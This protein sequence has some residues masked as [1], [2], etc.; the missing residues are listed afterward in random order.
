MGGKVI[1]RVIIDT[2]EQLP[3]IPVRHVQGKLVEIP[4]VFGTLHTGDYSIEGMERLWALQR[5]SIG[6]LWGTMYG[7]SDL[8]DGTKRYNQDR[9]REEFDRMQEYKR[10]GG[11]VRWIVE[12]TW[13]DLRR[14]AEKRYALW[15]Q[16]G[17]K[18]RQPASY[19][20]AKHAVLAI[21]ADYDV[22]IQF[23]ENRTEAAETIGY[24]FDRVIGQATNKTEAK[25]ARKRGLTLPWAMKEET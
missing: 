2:R 6:D 17:C 8:A 3:L 23:L 7:S 25:K 11:R 4:H 14:Y 15:M 19:Y 13:S 12:A 9:T 10:A 18:G 24:W 16:G 21:D 5:K 20:D 1:P 22:P